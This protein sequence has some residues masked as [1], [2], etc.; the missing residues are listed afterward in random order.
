MLSTARPATR[1]CYTSLQKSTHGTHLDPTHTDSALTSRLVW[2]TQRL[3]A[4]L[5]R[6]LVKVHCQVG[7]LEHRYGEKRSICIQFLHMQVDEE[8]SDLKRFEGRA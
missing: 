8:M 4:K 5:A 7:T 3:K 6:G 2:Y 1:L